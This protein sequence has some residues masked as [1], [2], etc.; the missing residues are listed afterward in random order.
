MPTNNFVDLIFMHFVLISILFRNIIPMKQSHPNVR[1]FYS[2]P[3][4]PQSYRWQ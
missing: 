1:L 2:H 3:Y 4:F